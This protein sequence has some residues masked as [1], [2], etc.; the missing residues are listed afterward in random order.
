MIVKMP[1]VSDD[2]PA[3]DCITHEI[4][5]YNNKNNSLW[6]LLKK[7]MKNTKF[8]ILPHASCFSKVIFS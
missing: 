8:P 4:K 3:R 7:Y 1:Q 5:V 2:D 6:Q